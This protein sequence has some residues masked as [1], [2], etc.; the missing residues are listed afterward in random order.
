MVRC[1][2]YYVSVVIRW[3]LTVHS[4][5]E[6]NGG[7]LSGSSGYANE[8]DKGIEFSRRF[9]SFPAHGRIIMEQSGD[10]LIDKISNYTRRAGISVRCVC[11]PPF[12][13]NG[14]RWMT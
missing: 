14:R 3:S 1:D 10:G 11:C 6:F 5:V 9:S 4:P 8:L 7:T 2:C 13:E 12:A